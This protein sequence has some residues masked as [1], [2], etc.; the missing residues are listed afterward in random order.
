MIDNIVLIS[1]LEQHKLT[2][3][4][5]EELQKVIYRLADGRIQNKDYDKL[6][7]DFEFYKISVKELVDEAK[8]ELARVRTMMQPTAASGYK[9]ENGKIVFFTDI[10]NGYREEYSTLEQ[11]AGQLNLLLHECYRLMELEAHLRFKRTP[12][13]VA[14]SDTCSHTCP[15]CGRLMV[16]DCFGKAGDF[17]RDC[18]Q[19]LDWSDAK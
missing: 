7:F 19:A 5:S 15:A 1:I 6:L 16:Y 14:H 8:E 17:C 2:D 12:M 4:Q 9:V 3:E 11:V 18:G 13:K 10:L